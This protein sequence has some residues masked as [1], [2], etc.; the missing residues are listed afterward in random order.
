MG[1]RL[2]LVLL[3]TSLCWA[4]GA[5][6]HVVIIVKENR[7][8]DSYF[9]H[10]PNV[11]DYPVTQ[12]LAKV[13]GVQ[14]TV[15]L[16]HANPAVAD[17]NCTHSNFMAV[18][19]VDDGKMDGFYA[20]CSNYGAYIYYDASDFPTYY[21]WAQRYGVA[22]HFFSSML[23]PSYPNHW[24]I[25]GSSSNGAAEDPNGI[26]GNVGWSCDAKHTGSAPPYVYQS[27]VQTG[28]VRSINT[29]TGLQYYG[30]MCT[31]G[32]NPGTACTC[33]SGASCSS[34]ACTGGGTCSTTS[35]IGGTAGCLCPT[36]TTMAQQ[37]EK[38]TLVSNGAV[39]PVSWAVYAPTF[40]QSG[41]IWNFASYSQQVRYGNEWFADSQ[42]N[43]ASASC[44]DP[45]G[46]GSSFYGKVVDWHCFDYDVQKNLLPAVS[47]LIPDGADSEHP[48][49][50]AGP[51]QTWTAAR[52]ANIF[53]NASLYATTA[54]F[55][56]WD[57]F[58][59]FYDHVPPPRLDFM[60]M[61]IR[62]P[63]LCLGPYCTNDVVRTNFEFAS[64]NKCIETSLMSWLTP[65]RNSLRPLTSRDLN[66]NNICAA[67]TSC[68][69]GVCTGGGMINLTQSPI[70]PP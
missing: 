54:V 22:D 57:D 23:G 42:C 11:Q 3:M 8:F 41:Y 32:T 46:W 61:G 58:G 66:A 65:P 37:L 50:P 21:A 24:Y 43:P 19:S 31:G 38:A 60:G 53:N 47:W 28:V 56:T 10:L 2:A 18:G 1:K 69:A 44:C 35:C 59:G 45:P 14:S 67:P 30:G 34:S 13:K 36:L 9:G 6:Q 40:N 16:T 25:F 52:M 63:A 29:T 5:I 7:S 55:L 70:S 15:T 62:V 17:Q 51:G 48:P 68:A 4:E 12:G 39:A 27:A 49:W 33:A 20:T 26:G 64:L